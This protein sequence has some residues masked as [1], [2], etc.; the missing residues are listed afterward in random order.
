MTTNE[1]NPLKRAYWAL[2]RPIAVRDGPTRRIVALRDRH[3]EELTSGF[4]RVA[5]SIF[6]PRVAKLGTWRIKACD[7]PRSSKNHHHHLSSRRTCC[8]GASS[9]FPARFNHNLSHLEAFK[10]PLGNNVDCG[11]NECN[12]D[13]DVGFRDDPQRQM[14][15]VEFRY[16][17]I[18]ASSIDKLQPTG[19]LYST[20]LE[21]EIRASLFPPSSLFLYY[22]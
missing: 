14:E 16:I 21:V 15:T 17:R 5:R 7:P 19:K 1:S 11:H 9:S 8:P 6:W 22:I 12:I 13:V 10:A 20:P 2:Q 4:L 18:L 3:R